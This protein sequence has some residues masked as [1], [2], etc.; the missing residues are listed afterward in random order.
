MQPLINTSP[1]VRFAYSVLVARS[2]TLL[3]RVFIVACATIVLTIVSGGAVFCY[4]PRASV[5]NSRG[6]LSPLVFIVVV[7]RLLRVVVCWEQSRCVHGESLT[8]GVTYVL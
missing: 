4:R 7:C 3:S 2:G 5:A 1:F 8:V 6:L